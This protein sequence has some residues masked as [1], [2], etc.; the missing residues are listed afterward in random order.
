VFLVALW[1]I[2]GALFVLTTS[3]PE[4]PWDHV[5]PMQNKPTYSDVY[6]GYR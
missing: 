1:V 4:E 3:I 5:K 2:V 6:G